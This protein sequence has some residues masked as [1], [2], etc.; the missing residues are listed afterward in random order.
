MVTD[1]EAVIVKEKEVSTDNSFEALTDSQI[2]IE[3]RRKKRQRRKRI[4]TALLCLAGVAAIYVGGMMFYAERFL[5][6]TVINHI[7]CSNLK[8]SAA[9]EKAEKALLNYTYTVKSKSGTEEI[10]GED[11][12]ISGNVA[13]TLRNVMEKQNS[14][15]WFC[16]GFIRSKAGDMEISYN[17]DALNEKIFELSCIK[18]TE[19]KVKDCLTQIVYNDEANL[20]EFGEDEYTAEASAP[21]KILD[22]AERMIIDRERFC[23][24]VK[25]DISKLNGKINLEYQGCYINIENDVKFINL[26]DNMNKPISAAIFYKND[27]GEN[28]AYL[29]GGSVNQWINVGDN[30]DVTINND[31]LSSYVDEL[32]AKYNTVGKERKF[33]TS[34]GTE[35]I[36]SGGDYGWIMDK[37]AEKQAIISAV[38]NGETIDRKPEFT[39]SAGFLGDT[40]F[41]NT[42]VEISISNQKI[43]FYKDGNLIVSSSIV[44]GN[45]FLGNSTETGVYK[46]KYKERNATL[47]G[48]DYRT[49]VG[50]WMPFNRGQGLHDATWRGSF[51]GQIYRG[52][53]SHG[54]VNLPLSTA[55]AIYGSVSAGDPVI[56]YQ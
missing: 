16:G 10:R 41:G 39:Q 53:G 14:K 21:Q 2:R 50:Y 42:Y 51:G 31:M 3:K 15:L 18:D 34:L 32:S 52:N 23:G 48:A 54:C 25:D 4:N 27:A 12:G 56:V 38:S 19:E 36:V 7:N 43:W 29:D 40:D 45:P 37:E 9:E 1:A 6:G 8:I 35:V 28:V 30:F 26:L 47:V 24:Y 33:K 49:P 44:T 46:L 13:D 20:F 55:S 5:P 22:E 11:I 17:E